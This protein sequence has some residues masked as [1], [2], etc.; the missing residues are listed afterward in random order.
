LLLLCVPATL[1]K[2]AFLFFV[3]CLYPLLRTRLPRR[4]TLGVVAA[5][6]AVA[7]MI[8]MVMKF[9]YRDNAGE[10]ALWKLPERVDFF[11]DWAHYVRVELNYGVVTAA[12]INVL[13]VILTV[14][15]WRFAWPRLRSAL[16][17][18]VLI[19]AAINVPLFLAFGHADE[20]RNLS[21]VFP[22]LVVMMGLWITQWAVPDGR[23]STP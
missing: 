18:H 11:L 21:F 16:R 15:L 8:N 20:L 5:L 19:A 6:M 13:N 7:A 10:M 14:A 12:G 17:Q 23:S 4:A 2:E 1:N 9:Q 3:P 22:C